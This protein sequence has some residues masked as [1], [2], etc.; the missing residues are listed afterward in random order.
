[1]S[2][3]IWNKFLTDRDKQFFADSGL[4]QRD[5]ARICR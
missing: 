5:D 2:E 1:M 4:L 3:P